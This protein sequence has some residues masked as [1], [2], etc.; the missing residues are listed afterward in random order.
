MSLGS[1]K[2]RDDLCYEAPFPTEFICWISCTLRG[3]LSRFIRLRTR[4][5][6]FALCVLTAK[7]TASYWFDGLF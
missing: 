4:S 2:I 5:E 6:I 7:H 1:K 3:P